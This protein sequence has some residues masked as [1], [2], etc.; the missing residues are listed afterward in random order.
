M[1]T[2][3]CFSYFAPPF[4]D[5]SAYISA[6]RIEQINALEKHAFAWHVYRADCGDIRDYDYEFYDLYAKYLYVQNKAVGASIDQ[7]SGL[8]AYA[9][10]TTEMICADKLEANVIYSRSMPPHGHVAAY[11]YKQKHPKAK[12]YAEFSDPIAR[13]F[14]YNAEAGLGSDFEHIEEIV[15]SAADVIIFTNRYQQDYMLSYIKKDLREDTL[16]KSC[17]MTH[18]VMDK[19]Y[20]TLAESNYL[21]DKDAINIGYFGAF[22][23]KTRSFYEIVRLTEN[24]KVI[25]HLFVTGFWVG[26]ETEADLFSYVSSLGLDATRVRLNRRLP[27]FSM[28]NTASKMDYLYVEDIRF[29]N[30]V[31]PCLPSKYADYLTATQKGEAKI[32][33][34]VQPNSILN[35]IDHNNLIKTRSITS[36]FAQSLVKH[37]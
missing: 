21:L 8:R 10:Q 7:Y 37:V 3:I 36:K 19:K 1:K 33:A 27:Y 20:V 29:S 28:L 14:D 13:G 34:L 26:T 12:W 9:N 4:A 5:T 6:K 15:Y 16:T 18:P 31:N 22:Y 35:T 25:L 24:P 32:I 23:E 2:A 11:Q 17:I 30:S